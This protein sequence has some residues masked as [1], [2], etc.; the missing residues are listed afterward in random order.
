MHCK[1]MV[2]ERTKEGLFIGIFPKAKKSPL[3]SSKLLDFSVNLMVRKISSTFVNMPLNFWP[4]TQT[5][6]CAIILSK[7]LLTSNGPKITAV[8]RCQGLMKR[9][10]FFPFAAT[11]FPFQKFTLTQHTIRKYQIHRPTSSKFNVLIFS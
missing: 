11:S 6:I 5:V 9:G 1:Q 2:K 3:P 8:T 7:F 10:L 4:S